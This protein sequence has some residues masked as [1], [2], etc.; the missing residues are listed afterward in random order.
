MAA[1]DVILGNTHCLLKAG[2]RGAFLR[3][4]GFWGG[5][6]SVKLGRMLSKAMAGIQNELTLSLEGCHGI[7]PQGLSILLRL[8]EQLET[9]GK[10][11]ELVKVPAKLLALFD[12]TGLMPHLQ[13]ASGSTLL[14]VR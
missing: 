7:D 8:Q 3:I 14:E 1:L 6:N 13:T 12:G 11:I 9:R 4:A 5:E 10:G 2:E